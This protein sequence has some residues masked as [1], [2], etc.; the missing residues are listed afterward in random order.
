MAS[1]DMS[2]ASGPRPL[3]L[4]RGLRAYRSALVALWLAF[5]AGLVGADVWYSRHLGAGDML[6]LSVPVGPTPLPLVVGRDPAELPLAA[7]P[8]PGLEE[9]TPEGKLPTVS[10]AGQMPFQAYAYPFDPTD[11]RPRIGV[12]LLDV[13]QQTGELTASIRRLPGS[14]GLAFSLFTPNLADAL[15]KARAAGHETLLTLPADS[16]DPRVYDPGPGALRTALSV[17]ENLQRLRLI[18][19]KGTGY[20]GFVVDPETA[21]FRNAALAEAFLDETRHRG[22]ATVTLDNGLATQGATQGSPVATASRLLDPLQSPAELD[23]IFAALEQQAKATGG[24]LLLV[25]VYPAVIERLTRWLP[26]LAT[27]GIALA[28]ASA[29]VTLPA[30]APPAAPST[31]DEIPPS[32]EQIPPVH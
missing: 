25:P 23:D 3:W 9:S 29:F 8:L 12:V 31:T 13:G 20:V 19:G 30:V 27:R 16:M 15:A 18:M 11:T 26:E 4:K 24:A 5:L 21:V 28:P 7:A 1:L 14:V 22:L 2:P 17:G 32:H 10:T 6:S